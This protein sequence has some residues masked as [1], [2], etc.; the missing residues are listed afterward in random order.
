MVVFTAELFGYAGAFGV[1]VDATI[2][3]RVGDDLTSPEKST[4]ANSVRL[5]M[6]EETEDRL[7]QAMRRVSA[8]IL[9]LIKVS[10]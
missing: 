1:D 7:Q 3:V 10:R 4:R 6:K 2:S 5:V 8:E 9:S